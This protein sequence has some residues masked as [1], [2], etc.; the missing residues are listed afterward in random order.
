MDICLCGY[1]AYV[2]ADSGYV[3]SFPQVVQ[4]S[5]QDIELVQRALEVNRD[6]GNSAPLMSLT[7]KIKSMM[8]IQ[9]DLPPVKF[10]YTII[11]DFQHLTAR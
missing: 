10:L 6:L 5:E 2:R 8:G 11:K 7:E 9:T 4:L 1:S 3:V